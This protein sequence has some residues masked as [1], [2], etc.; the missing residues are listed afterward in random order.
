MRGPFS[1]QCWR[2]LVSLGRERPGVGVQSESIVAAGKFL[3]GDLQGLGRLVRVVNIVGDQL[4]IRVVGNVRF[5][6][7]LCFESGEGLR[8]VIF[9]AGAVESFG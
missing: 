6:Q 1:S 8:R 9:A 3:P 5:A 7:R 2:R 4:M